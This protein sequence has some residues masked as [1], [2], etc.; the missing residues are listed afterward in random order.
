[1][2]DEGR[3][4]LT[5]SQRGVLAVLLTV[6]GLLVFLH[7]VSQWLW[8]HG[9]SVLGRTF[10]GAQ[11]LSLD[12]EISVPT[13]W[14]QVAVAAIAGLATLI[15][16]FERRR[17]LPDHRYWAGLGVILLL[18]SLDE[19]AEI[20]EHLIQP[21]RDQFGITGGVLWFAWL[22][23]GLAAL[24]LF[25]VVYLRFWLRLRPPVRW[26]LGLAGGLYLLGAVGFEM[27]GGVYESSRGFQDFGYALVIAC[28]EGLE[29]V[30]Q[31]VAIYGLLTMLRSL[32]GAAGLRLQMRA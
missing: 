8:Y 29:L 19:G 6:D 18:M 21:M 9:E 25:G 20:H 15:A 24:A 11:L 23:P 7:V 30:G 32:H 5:V 17:G 22:I 4:E 31:T 3:A 26:Q 10:E 13:W 28:E 16:L 14:Q 2:R 27:L 12:R 1:M